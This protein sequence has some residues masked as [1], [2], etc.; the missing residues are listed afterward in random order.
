M[1]VQRS[2]TTRSRIA[3]KSE[4]GFTLAGVIVLVTIVM[5]FAAY[6]IPR[7]WSTIMKRE[8]EKQ[9]IFAMQQYAKAISNFRLKNNTYPT[10][11]QQLKDARMPRM[12]RGLKGELVDALTGEVDWLV[13]P[14]AA[15]ASL[16]QRN[17]AGGNPNNPPGTV[18]PPAVNP[19]TQT[20][21]TTDT[22]STSTSGTNPQGAA[23]LPGIPIKDYA[24]GPFIGV[25]PA[26]HGK[27]LLTLYGADTY[28]TWVYTSIDYEQEKLLRVAAAGAV[29][30]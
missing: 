5:I 19:P 21:S 24:G 7:Q 9:T 20:T 17:L 26:A 27:S 11:P 14:Q 4:S 16:P 28:E 6:T 10:S 1:G 25:R 13:I 2:I 8:R 3:R 12:I 18:T 30:H 22:S 23:S 15:A 29:F